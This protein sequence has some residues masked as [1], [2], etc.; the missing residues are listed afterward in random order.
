VGETLQE[1]GEAVRQAMEELL[2][3][4]S[5]HT[6]RLSYCARLCAGQAI[7][8]GMVEG[9]CKNV[10]GKR[11]K[12]TAARWKLGNVQKMAVLCCCCYSDFWTPYWTA[13]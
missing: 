7:G 13:A 9:A 5:K 6:N 3:Y 12:Q 2:G 11:L 10:I 8:S 4:F 1:Q